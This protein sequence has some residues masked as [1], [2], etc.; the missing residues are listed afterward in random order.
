MQDWW[1]VNPVCHRKRRREKGFGAQ[2]PAH[3]ESASLYSK[4]GLPPISCWQ[5][6]PVP[7][8]CDP[9]VRYLPSL[10]YGTVSLP[11]VNFFVPFD[12]QFCWSVPQFCAVCRLSLSLADSFSH[13]RPKKLWRIPKASDVGVSFTLLDCF[14]WHT[15]LDCLIYPPHR[16]CKINLCYHLAGGGW[17]E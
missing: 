9:K 4:P 12:G 5:I 6:E 15:L 10:L 7:L 11:S 13:I 3:P 17:Y 8:G 16:G 1:F 14:A 2:R